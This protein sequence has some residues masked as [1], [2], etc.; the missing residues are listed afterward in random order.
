ML[1][2]HVQVSMRNQTD[3]DNY[4]A[5]HMHDST[6]SVQQAGAPEGIMK[7]LKPRTPASTMDCRVVWWPALSGTM[8]PQNPVS[9]M[10]SPCMATSL[11]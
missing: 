4:A 9:T 11:P 7:D 3:T 6:V 10:S 5:T 8:P 1:F 2:R